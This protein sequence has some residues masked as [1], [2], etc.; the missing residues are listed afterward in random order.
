[1]LIGIC[2]KAGSG[3]DTIADILVR[4]HGFV[5]I[6]LADPMKRAC[7]EWFE[8]PSDT[9]WG[10]SEM[11]NQA[12]DRLGGLTARKALQL[13][14][15]EFGRACC[16][17][18]WVN[19]AIRTARTLLVAD[20][21]CRYSYSAPRGLKVLFQQG[22][23]NGVPRNDSEGH[24]E[25]IQG[26]VISDVRFPNEVTAIRAAGGMIWKAQHGAGLQGTAS[27]HES[28]RHVDSLEADV[29]IPRGP[30]AE[31]PAVVA[32]LLATLEEEPFELKDNR[33]LQRA[34]TLTRKP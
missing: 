25:P 10:P 32:R 4:E 2:G 29:A 20:K 34:A 13:L 12:W 9:L 6:A 27:E 28:E 26:V 16:E 21:Y 17:D 19:I 8:W 23:S 15:T 7:A 14:G 5:K 31:V 33:R 3:K 22:L 11:R 1:M 30:L 18:V 24:D